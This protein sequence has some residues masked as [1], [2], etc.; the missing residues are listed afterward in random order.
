MANY[1]L[2]RLRVSFRSVILWSRGSTALL[3]I[4]LFHGLV[5]LIEE[6]VRLGMLLS[7]KRRTPLFLVDE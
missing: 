7:K 5:C 2:R 6:V 3:G 4:D 1:F